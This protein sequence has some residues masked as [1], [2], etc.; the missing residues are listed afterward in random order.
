MFGYFRRPGRQNSNPPSF[1]DPWES[2]PSPQRPENHNFKPIF[3]FFTILLGWH[4]TI[5]MVKDGYK[6]RFAFCGPH[7]LP[8][9]KNRI[10]ENYFCNRP[11]DQ[12]NRSGKNIMIDH[13][14]GH[15]NE[16]KSDI[17]LRKNTKS[18]IFLRKNTK[19]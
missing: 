2:I 9:Q 10:H 8:V 16:Q 5:L 7:H 13:G 6:N 17:F 14:N 4:L 11:P 3:M 1:L 19:K 18:D 12:N 15:G